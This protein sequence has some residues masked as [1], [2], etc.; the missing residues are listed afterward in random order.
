MTRNVCV[1][2]LLCMI[3]SAGAGK[4]GLPPIEKGKTWRLVWQD[5]FKG[6]KVDESK[7]ERIGD[8]PRRD[9][10]WVKADV[11]LDGR[12]HL[13]LRTKKDGDRF[14][15]G[16][17]RTRGKF[18]HRFGYWEARCKFPKQPGHWPAFW[19]FPTAGVP[20]TSEEGRAGT[21]IDVM[22]KAWLASKVQHALHWNGYAEHHKSV[23]HEVRQ[24]G[25][26]KG[27]HTFGVW[28]KPDEYVFYVDGKETWRTVAGG[29]CQVPVYAKLTEEIGTWA[30]KIGEAKLPDEFV[31]DY[32]RVYDSEILPDGI[33]K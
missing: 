27:F 8:S 6:T 2:L 11:Y 28:W 10:F 29:V 13:V 16:A 15:C 21:E 5:E 30:G 4:A 20:D 1:I 17:V 31:V 18:E 33:S 3:A 26:N 12:G 24:D 23:G 32:V 9:G 7:W 22:E 14:T 25:F 19:L